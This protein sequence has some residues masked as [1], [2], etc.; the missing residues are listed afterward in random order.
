VAVTAA[1]AALWVMRPCR[2]ALVS[3]RYLD[4][5]APPSAQGLQV[6][7]F[8]PG[9]GFLRGGAANPLYDGAYLASK[10]NAAVF[11]IQYRCVA[12]GGRDEGGRD[13]WRESE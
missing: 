3:C 5:Y 1:P 4:V 9:G 8:I 6:M 2:A 10:H 12:C 13:G 7:V 11:V